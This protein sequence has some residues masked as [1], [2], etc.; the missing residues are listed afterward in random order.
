MPMDS[1]NTDNDIRNSISLN[2]ELRESCFDVIEQFHFDDLFYKA[3]TL[4]KSDDRKVRL[5]LQMRT[6]DGTV[7]LQVQIGQYSVAAALVDPGICAI[8]D[9]VHQDTACE[10]IIT[11]LKD[12]LNTRKIWQLSGSLP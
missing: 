12:S 11:I 8:D 7:N 9:P 4:H 6:K 3:G 2:R 1:I 10:D 5:D